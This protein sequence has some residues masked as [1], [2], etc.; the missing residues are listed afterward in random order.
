VPKRRKEKREREKTEQKCLGI[1]Q[2]LV[3]KER[4]V[5]KVDDGKDD[6]EGR[7]DLRRISAAS[8]TDTGCWAMAWRGPTHLIDHR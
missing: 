6:D 2:T 8:T 1:G 5:N 7:W 4:D 3:R